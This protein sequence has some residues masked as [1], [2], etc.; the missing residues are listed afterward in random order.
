[1]AQALPQ[2]GRLVTCEV[3]QASAAI[4][5]RFWA[6]SPFGGRIELRLGPAMETLRR[7]PGPWDLVFI[8][9]DKESYPAYWDAAVPKLRKGGLLVADNALWSGR[10]LR[11]RGPEDRAIALF[12]RKALR[13]PRMERVLL[14][15]RDGMLLAVKR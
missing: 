10:V 6:R 13:D 7:E 8:D 2:G 3:D 1:M 14:T 11:P 9:A 15:V 4:A 5:R 12:N